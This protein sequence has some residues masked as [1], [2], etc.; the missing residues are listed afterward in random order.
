MFG[1]RIRQMLRNFRKNERPYYCPWV[2]YWME[3]DCEICPSVLPDYTRGL[4]KD[5]YLGHYWKTYNAFESVDWHNK[6]HGTK[7]KKMKVRR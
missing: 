4:S 2:Q 3:P 5:G 6:T 1:I 7:D